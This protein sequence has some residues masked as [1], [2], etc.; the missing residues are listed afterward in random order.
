M[1]ALLAIGTVRQHT[2]LSA[3]AEDAVAAG[4]AALMAGLLAGDAARLAAQASHATRTAVK[5]GTA[6]GQ[7]IAEKAARDDTRIAGFARQWRH[8]DELREH[9]GERSPVNYIRKRTRLN[10]RTIQRALQ[11]ISRQ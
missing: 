3:G 5:G 10:A 11:R 7:A 9:N 6:R 1:F 8:S 4:Q 2:S